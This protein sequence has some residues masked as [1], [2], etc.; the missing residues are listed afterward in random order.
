MR[1]YLDDDSVQRLLIRLLRSGGHDVET[2]ADAGM[3]GESDA[4]QLTHAVKTD[5]ALVS[6]NHKDFDE[7]HELVNRTGGVHTG[8]L[9]VRRENNR[10]RDMS[11]RATVHAL[12]NL[13]ASGAQIKIEVT[14][15]NHW[16]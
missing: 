4:V 7:L 14:V 2:P 15:L 6:R 5:R 9:I 11:P 3:V 12:T 10:S 8:I 13:L 16:R 1:L